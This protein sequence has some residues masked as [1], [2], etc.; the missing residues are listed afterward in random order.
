[1]TDEAPPPQ[2]GLMSGCFGLAAVPLG[3]G[4]L[5]ILWL[6]FLGLFG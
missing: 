4:L 2:S 1:M 6:M 3:M 5:F